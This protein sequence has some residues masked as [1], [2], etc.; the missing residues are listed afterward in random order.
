MLKKII[1][2]NKS[3]RQFG[4]MLEPW[5]DQADI[6]EGAEVAIEG[7]FSSEEEVIIDVHEDGF[8]SIWVPPDSNIVSV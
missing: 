7:D 8:L 4:L 1:I 5:A 6:Q 2:R 3:G